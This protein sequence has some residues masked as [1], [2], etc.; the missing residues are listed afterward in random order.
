L[1]VDVGVGVLVGVG[2]IV[3]VCVTVGIG[4]N[5]AVAVGVAVGAAVAA[6]FAMAV[7]AGGLLH[8]VIKRNAKTI[9][10]PRVLKCCMGCSLDNLLPPL[11]MSFI[12]GGR[13][14]WRLAISP[15]SS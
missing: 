8:A 14:G 11:L 2:V 10:P 12:G 9:T 4:V 3:G 5:V 7:G 13:S 15:V 1:G 6:M